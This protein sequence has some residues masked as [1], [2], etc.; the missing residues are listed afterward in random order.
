[1][2]A[3]KS[4]RLAAAL[5]LGM[6]AFAYSAEPLPS[7]GC[8]R[9][10]LVLTVHNLGP[11]G[12]TVVL[13]NG[14]PLEF[15]V[16]SQGVAQVGLP[17]N[18]QRPEYKLQAYLPDADG[19]VHTGQK[20]A[21]TSWVEVPAGCPSAAPAAHVVVYKSADGYACAIRSVAHLPRWAPEDVALGHTT[22]VSGRHQ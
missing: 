6:A 18:D 14:N 17:I 13:N 21:C 1:M 8:G 10:T 3:F 19:L 2:I 5:G 11:D 15:A 7:G 9:S 20:P 22:P 12:R 16:G 4:S